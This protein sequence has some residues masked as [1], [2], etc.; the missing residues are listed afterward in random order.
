MIVLQNKTLY[1]ML[2]LLLISG[3]VAGQEWLHEYFEESGDTSK[4]LNYYRIRAW[5]DVHFKEAREKL[6]EE[7]K[8]GELIGEAEDEEI[9]AYIKY[10]RWE[11]Y[12][13]SRIRQNGSMNHPTYTNV[14]RHNRKGLRVAG[15]G[16][17][18]RSIGFTSNTG[19]YWGMGR[20]ECMGFHPTDPLIFYVG[21]VGGGIWKT[22]DGG[23][24]YTALGDQLPSSEVGNIVVD[25]Q[26]P[27]N[28]YISL[29][30]PKEVR[31]QGMGVYK[32]EDG[33]N[34]WR[35]TGLATNFDEGWTIL[36][37]V[38]SET[39]PSVILAGRDD[40]LYR[41]ENAGVS[42]ELVAGWR[43]EDLAW[44][45]GSSTRVYASRREIIGEA[46]FY[47]SE[48]AGKTWN[49]MTEAGSAFGAK[50]LAVTPANPD[51]LA[52]VYY[53]QIFL[54]E[55]Q[56]VSFTHQGAAPGYG[57]FPLCIS[58]SSDSVYYSGGVDVHKSGDKGAS[59]T[60]ITSWD[61][62]GEER[63]YVHADVRNIY[64]NRADPGVVYFCND[65]GV[66][67]YAEGN[68]AWQELTRGLQITQY[69]TVS[70]A[71]TDSV[72]VTGGTQDNGGNIRNADGSWR[73]TS[74]GDAFSVAIDPTDADVVYSSYINGVILRSRNGYKTDVTISRNIQNPSTAEFE[75]PFVLDPGNPKVIVAG[76]QEV[77]RSEDQGDTWS[78]ISETL[79]TAK[80][81]DVLAVAGS[82]GRV[83]FATED[84]ILYM[85]RDMGATAWQNVFTA[86]DK[87]TGIEV[88]PVNADTAWITLGGWINGEKV[89]YTYDA[90]ATWHNYS[91]GLPNVP[92]NTIIYEK[93]S[94]DALYVGTDIGVYYRNR[95]MSSWIPY[96]AGLPNV[97]VEDLDINYSDKHLRAATFGR[98]IWEADLYSESDLKVHMTGPIYSPYTAEG[99]NLIIS[100]TVTAYTGSVTKVEFYD[101]DGTV[102]L[103]ED[104]TYPY[105]YDWNN[106]PAGTHRLSVKAYNSEGATGWSGVN[107]VEVQPWR[108]PDNPANAVPGIDYSYYESESAWM[109]MSAFN[110]LTAQATGITTDFNLV[111]PY[112]D[113]DFGFIYSGL[114]NVAED[115]F[116]TFYT[117]SDDG[118]QL[119][120]GDKLVVDNDG[121]HGLGDV[122]GR[123]VALKAGMHYITVKYFNSGGDKGLQIS[124]AGI[125][126]SKQVIPADV[127]YRV[128]NAPE[129]FMILPE[130]NQTYQSPVTLQA[131]AFDMDGTINKVVF[132]NKAGAVA[133]KELST[134][135]YTYTWSV[136]PGTYEVYAVAT[137]NQG[138]TTVSE[139]VTFTVPA[140][141]SDI[142]GPSCMNKYE[143]ARFELKADLRTNAS[144]YNWYFRD[145]AYQTLQPVPGAAYST[146]LSTG[147]WFTGGQLCI[148]VNYAGYPYYKEYCV[149]ISLCN[150]ALRASR[151]EPEAVIAPN[152]SESAFVLTV[153]K[154]VRLLT[155]SNSFGQIV[156]TT[157]DV[158]E[159]SAVELGKEFSGGTYTIQLNYADHTQ[160]YLK[161]VKIK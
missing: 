1:V 23:L 98:G 112:R 144:G 147:Q 153:T 133:L 83:I 156:Y 145:G 36:D 11:H 157:S 60:Q 81:L 4:S 89:Y 73:N 117:S 140:Q 26:N 64:Y 2:C 61:N 92:V 76:Y 119:Y 42:W 148:G 19:G 14:N 114:I 87:I 115:G 102:K 122:E 55:D 95:S 7:L 158:A 91:A 38:M 107:I 99:S 24:S 29:G 121:T 108:M 84:S 93:N 9:G 160:E 96:T 90:G 132:Y 37:M 13:K 78:R 35:P 30:H 47:F 22:T 111:T 25:Y 129:V 125:G 39:D 28:I 58:G 105:S 120:I 51:L 17:I 10:Q 15:G 146:D 80:G 32:S 100:A 142:S 59:F 118:T 68:G 53:G 134:G 21:S 54:S 82:D 127:L 154:P 62:P 49:V 44:M 126:I 88:H 86:N 8:K 103:G 50:Q 152:P 6:Q 66:Y 136:S 143:N 161:V 137:D 159:G 33:G 63:A 67:R 150:N 41:T 69:Y 74:G 110:G 34:S 130:N 45:P 5:A 79:T 20:A 151:E 70:C 101:N 94:Q 52:C 18:W 97:P 16:N 57:F 116:Y 43:A 12:W 106:V 71:Q 113:N 141:L 109:Q 3:R 131:G 40:G 72:I 31:T 124:Y 149:H 128:N 56:G 46:G 135:P 75:T 85:T 48:D 104:M 155:V 65:G 77:Y 123:P 138:A 139:T 27:N